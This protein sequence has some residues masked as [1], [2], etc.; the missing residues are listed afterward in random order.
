M[1]DLHTFTSSSSPTRHVCALTWL[2]YGVDGAMFML[3]EGAVAL[4]DHVE[5]IRKLARE[6]ESAR[7]VTVLSGGEGDV[8]RHG[9]A[10]ICLILMLILV[11]M[12][13][14]VV[15]THRA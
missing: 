1:H 10:R 3:F 13:Q 12:S 2:R 4:E 7:V 11:A 15:Q 14:G 9:V 5:A 6:A 8:D